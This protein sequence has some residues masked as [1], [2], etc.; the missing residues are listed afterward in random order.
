MLALLVLLLLLILPG[1]PPATPGLVELLLF[2]RLWEDSEVSTVETCELALA[3]VVVTE[4]LLVDGETV[5]EGTASSVLG[6]KVPV[7]EALLRVGEGM[8][9]GEVKLPSVGLALMLPIL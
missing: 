5:S 6:M 3:T 7:E 2:G 9:N 1:P 4:S 8:T